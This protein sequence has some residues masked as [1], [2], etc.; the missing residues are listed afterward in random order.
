[1]EWVIGP[2]VLELPAKP[3][4]DLQMQ[5]GRDSHVP[6][7]EKSMKIRPD[8]KPIADLVFTTT[9]VRFDVSG[10]KDRK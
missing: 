8:Q 4:A 7:V 6:K 5:F 9:R 10:F 3:V 2:P 1:V